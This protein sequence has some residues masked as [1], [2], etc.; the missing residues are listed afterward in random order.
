MTTE[1]T[2]IL[3]LPTYI[4]DDT[5]GTSSFL[6]SFFFPTYAIVTVPTQKNLIFKAQLFTCILYFIL[7][8]GR[9]GTG[10]YRYL[11]TYFSYGTFPEQ[12]NSNIFLKK[13]LC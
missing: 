2:Y 3:Y 5:Y 10:T 12:E 8:L 1:G 6:L 13:K 11:P 7:N 9:Y 4:T